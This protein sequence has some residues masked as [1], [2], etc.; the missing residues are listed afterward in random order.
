MFEKTGLLFLLF[1]RLADSAP[2]PQVRTVVLTKLWNEMTNFIH[3]SQ[4][5]YTGL[6]TK[7]RI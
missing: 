2:Q 5:M 4:D 6:P 3:K 7:K 1:T